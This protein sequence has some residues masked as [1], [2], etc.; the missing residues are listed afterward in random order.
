MTNC[1]DYVHC[2]VT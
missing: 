1:S 2:S